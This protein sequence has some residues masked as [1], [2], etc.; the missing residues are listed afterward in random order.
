MKRQLKL[1]ANH[2][3]QLARKELINTD[4]QILK[5]L[6]KLLP[7]GDPLVISRE[8]CRKIIREKKKK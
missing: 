5:R 6:E 4:Y 2:E 7:V 3:E 8:D 1:K